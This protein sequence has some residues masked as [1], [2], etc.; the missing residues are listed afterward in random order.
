MAL[1]AD[2]TEIGWEDPEVVADLEETGAGEG[3]MSRFGS[4][5]SRPAGRWE[6]AMGVPNVAVYNT[7]DPHLVLYLTPEGFVF[8]GGGNPCPL[9]PKP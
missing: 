2:G 8:S 6:V 1:P 3:L 7:G 4:I 9:N 5:H